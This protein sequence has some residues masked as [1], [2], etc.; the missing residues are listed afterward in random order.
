MY[1][2]ERFLCALR[3]CFLAVVWISLT[4]NVDL[5][6]MLRCR[7]REC[8]WRTAPLCWENQALAWLGQRGQAVGGTRGGDMHPSIACGFLCSPVWHAPHESALPHPAEPTSKVEIQKMVK[9]CV[10]KCIFAALGLGGFW[11]LLSRDDSL[12]KSYADLWGLS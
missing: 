10:K 11:A 4:N 1:C 3:L 8:L 6:R 5:R 2:R 9:R 12:V 7:K